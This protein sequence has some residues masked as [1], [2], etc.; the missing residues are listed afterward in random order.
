MTK[1]IYHKLGAEKGRLIVC[2]PAGY[3]DFRAMEADVR[4]VMGFVS[5]LPTQYR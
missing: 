4:K 1:Y 5:G 3:R 2:K